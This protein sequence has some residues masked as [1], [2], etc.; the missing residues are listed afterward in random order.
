MPYQ[1][2]SPNEYLVVTGFGINQFR[3]CKKQF[4]LPGLQ[5]C[6]RFDVTPMTFALDLKV[7]SAEKL[8]FVLPAVYT[9][10]VNKD[11]PKSLE[12]YA[13]NFVNTDGEQAIDMKVRNVVLG[14][15]EGETRVVISTLSIEELFKSRKAFLD[16]VV[17]LIQ[18]ELTPLGLKLYNMNLKE[19]QDTQ[20][21][22]YFK[23]LMQ[24]TYENAVNQARID[25]AEAKMRGEIGEKE[26][27]AKGIQE[28]ARIEADQIAFENQRRTAIAES[29]T[30][31]EIKQTEFAQRVRL[32]KIETN[33][34]AQMKEAELN[35]ELEK[36]RAMLNVEKIRASELAGTTVEA[37]KIKAIAD[38][39]A[40]ETAKAT[41][42]KQYEIEK[43]AEGLKKLYLAQAGGIKAI[44]DAFGNPA[45]AL[46]FLMMEKGILQ[47]LAQENAK[48]IQGLQPR[49]TVW[50]TGGDAGA[51]D[52]GK[53]VRDIFQTLPPLLGTIKDQ[54]GSKPSKSLRQ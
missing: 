44:V 29:N 24:K 20:D 36:K 6:T 27:K 48:A 53:S 19:L 12:T 5:S 50:T 14:I 42:M 16:T 35:A 34:N 7:M 54:T 43:Q 40:Y 3:I 10:G 45:L 41:D 21:T 11:D 13:K 51:T 30:L 26:R 37:E 39:R 31:L 1:I 4:V 23:Q 33:Q 32:T 47:Q 52:P 17:P 15:I 8:P 22:A 25:V 28:V 46:Q 38:A 2:A 9:I 18:G 49:I